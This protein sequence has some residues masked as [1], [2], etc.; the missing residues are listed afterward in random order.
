MPTFVCSYGVGS[1]GCQHIIVAPSS[2]TATEGLLQ[3]KYHTLVH[4][5]MYIDTFRQRITKDFF[6]C[7]SGH[8]LATAV[9][10]FNNLA[11]HSD[12]IIIK[13]TPYNIVPCFLKNGT[14]L[15]TWL[16][17]TTYILQRLAFIFKWHIRFHSFSCE[18]E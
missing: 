18:I 9:N 16:G 7:T 10:W 6:L 12:W 14:K 8:R 17:R 4:L 5:D 3:N 1:S 13:D 15:Q 11:L 2:L